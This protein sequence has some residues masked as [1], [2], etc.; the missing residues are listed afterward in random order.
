MTRG[1]FRALMDRRT[2][3]QLLAPCLLDE[4]PPYVFDADRGAWNEFRDCLA[5]ILNVNQ[6]NIRVVGSA[7]LGYSLK[8]GANLADL[9]AFVEGIALHPRYLFLLFPARE[10][11]WEIRSMRPDPSIRVLG[12]FADVDVFIATNYALRHELGGWRS[13]A[14]RDVKLS[15]RTVWTN[16]FHTY[17]PI[18]TTNVHDVVTGAI[19]GKYFKTE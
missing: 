11:V 3:R 16:L 9:E 2:D 14:W 17:R 8:P 15:A 1:E 18:I 10:G 12:R 7:R 4:E 6:S 5:G 19:N 13:R